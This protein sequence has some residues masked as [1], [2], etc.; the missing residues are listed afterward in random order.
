MRTYIL[1]SGEEGSKDRAK[2]LM[3]ALEGRCRC[4]LAHVRRYYADEIPFED[5][6]WWNKEKAA[7]TLDAF[8]IEGLSSC[9]YEYEYSSGMAVKALLEKALSDLDTAFCIVVAPSA[10]EQ[11]ADAIVKNLEACGKDTSVRITSDDTGKIA[12]SFCKRSIPP[13]LEI[14]ERSRYSTGR[15]LAMDFNKEETK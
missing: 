8:K 4:E 5:T 3:A 15:F 9:A 1:V 13:L 6:V 10:S 14:L 12:F 7:M 11:A 2:A